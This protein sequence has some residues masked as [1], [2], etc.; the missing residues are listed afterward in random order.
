MNPRGLVTGYFPLQLARFTS[1][2]SGRHST[3]ITSTVAVS[4]P[5]SESHGECRAGG[6]ASFPT[7]PVRE[8]PPQPHLSASPATGGGQA[9]AL[10][11]PTSFGDGS[12]VGAGHSIW[13]AKSAAPPAPR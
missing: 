3:G 4:A 5:T 2:V 11:S 6:G 13:K 12:S 8:A 10:T 1:S 9:T 7:T